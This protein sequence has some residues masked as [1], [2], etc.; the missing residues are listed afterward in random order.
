MR[1]TADEGA[2]AAKNGLRGPVSPESGAR[3]NPGAVVLREL[4]MDAAKRDQAV[5]QKAPV[6]FGSPMAAVLGTAFR[7][8]P[9]FS[10]RYFKARLQVTCTGS[11]DTMAKVG[12]AFQMRSLLYAA[13]QPSS[14]RVAYQMHQLP[15]ASMEFSWIMRSN[16]SSGCGLPNR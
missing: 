15:A 14:T 13:R 2:D 11:S 10:I 16:L 6:A 5:R 9:Q 1:S 7:A 3:V 8:L 12:F 4:A